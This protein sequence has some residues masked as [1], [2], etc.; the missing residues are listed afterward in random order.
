MVELSTTSYQPTAG[1]ERHV[2]A[3]WVSCFEPGCDAPATQAE[4]DHRI[5]WPQ[6][7]TEPGNLW[8]GCK[9]G[10]T[11]KHAPG[12]R[13]TQAPDGSFVLSSP[14]FSSARLNSSP[15]ST[16][17][18]TAELARW[19]WTGQA[20]LPPLTIIGLELSPVRRTPGPGSPSRA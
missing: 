13:I 12:Y 5:P 18:A 2:A 15:S 19:A 6:G 8:P 3:E 7:P 16:R 1:I 11:T 14:R 4:N 9:R 10:H 20:G 17:S